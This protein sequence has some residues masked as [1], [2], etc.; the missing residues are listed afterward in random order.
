M[1]ATPRKNFSI[2]TSPSWTISRAAA[3]PTTSS[4]SPAR[5]TFALA[6]SQVSDFQLH[7]RQLIVD[8][9]FVQNLSDKPVSIEAL[10]GTET[11]G[12]QL[13]KTVSGQT[14]SPDMIAL[15][16]D[17]LQPSETIA[18]PLRISFV[19]PGRFQDQFSDSSTAEKTFKTIRAAKPGTIFEMAA[20]EGERGNSKAPRE[21]RSAHAA[22][23]H[24]L[25]FRSGNQ[26]R[27]T[28]PRR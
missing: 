4:S 16:T 1:R 28:C 11:G 9:A 27:W 8:V 18:F 6:V 26:T 20:E 21:F 17:Q 25:C 14:S 3:G 5:L 2:G 10:L 15:V 13:R 12:N 19:L 7:I 24:D 22:Q 23:T